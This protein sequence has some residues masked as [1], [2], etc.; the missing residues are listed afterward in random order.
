MGS[1]GAWASGADEPGGGSDSDNESQAAPL[2]RR[3]RLLRND[4]SRPSLHL[5][6]RWVPFKQSNG[7]AIYHHDQPDDGSGIGG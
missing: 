1:T 7:V 3:S 4:R 2:R 6:E 5:S